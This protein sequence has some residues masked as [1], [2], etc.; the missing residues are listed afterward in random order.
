MNHSLLISVISG[1]VG[2]FLL[3][4][5]KEYSFNVICG[6]DRKTFSDADCPVY[7]NFSEVKENV[8]VVI[9]FS[10]PALLDEAIDFAE[11]QGCAL[12]SG[13]TALLVNQKLKLKKLAQNNAVCWANNFSKNI[14]PFLNCAISLKSHLKDFDVCMIEEHNKNKKD[15][16]SGTANYIAER[17]GIKEI[18]SIRGGNVSGIHKIIFLGNGEEIEI[19]H[20][21]Y[22]KSLFAKGAL[23]CANKLLEKEKGFY[24]V[25]DL[26]TE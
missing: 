20:R 6:V 4:T 10:S 13:T 22:D 12:V 3:K 1:K 19:S 8:D 7:Q 18:H 16:P 25:S 26:I 5:A 14:I 23:Y 11:K 21:A 15:S 9:D 2:S 24:T 17:L